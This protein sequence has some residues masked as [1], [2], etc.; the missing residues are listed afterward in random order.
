MVDFEPRIG[1]SAWRR[2]A[3]LYWSQST[4]YAGWL[5]TNRLFRAE[6]DELRE[7]YR[8]KV[9]RWGRF[10]VLNLH[11]LESSLASW[12]PRRWP[13]PVSKRDS[14]FQAGI[15]QI[16]AVRLDGLPPRL[17]PRRIGIEPMTLLKD[18]PA[19][20]TPGGAKDSCRDCT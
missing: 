5:V 11:L 7:K 15:S 13:G 6:L 17:I 8:D 3:T 4:A 16:R 10:P 19:Q 14:D 1:G 2:P 9:R 18:I 20:V 12:R